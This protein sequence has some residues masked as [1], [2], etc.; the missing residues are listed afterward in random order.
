MSSF[1]L[2]SPG[3]GLETV[4]D[5]LPAI[6]EEHPETL[7][8]IAGRTHPGVAQR[9][10]ERYRPTLQQK[11]LELGLAKHV[12]FDDRFLSVAEISELL[13]VT[14]VFVTPYL[15]REQT[16]S[17]ALTFGVAAGCAVVSTPYRYAEDLLATGAGEIVPFADAA[18]VSAAIC[19]FID[20]PELLQAALFST[21]RPTS[22]PGC[23]TS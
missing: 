2:L 3:K 14:A 10:G 16:S 1:G 8:V 23:G 21:T 17:G 19:R 4:L 9:E 22:G 13:A 12:E 20:E 18:A 6:I 7:Y 5:A 15:D 11:V